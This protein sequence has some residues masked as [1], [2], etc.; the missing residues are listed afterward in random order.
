M[1]AVESKF[2]ALA[3]A[4]LETEVVRTCLDWLSLAPLTNILPNNSTMSTKTTPRI[5]LSELFFFFI[6]SP[7]EA[8]VAIFFFGLLLVSYSS[9][10]FRQ[11]TVISSGRS[12]PKRSYVLWCA[13]STISLDDLLQTGSDNRRGA[14]HHSL[15][16][17]IVG[18]ECKHGSQGDRSCKAYHCPLSSCIL[19]RRNKKPVTVDGRNVGDYAPQAE[20]GIP[21]IRRANSYVNGQ[22]DW[23][24]YNAQPAQAHRIAPEPHRRAPRRFDGH[25]VPKIP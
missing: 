13:S 3:V 4:V 1:V 14:W 10:Q 20:K 8:E 9:W 5:I 2:D 19:N 22:M 16:V 24:A 7:L 6:V 21:R 17:A 18:I 12:L 25:I 15:F 23:F 11:R